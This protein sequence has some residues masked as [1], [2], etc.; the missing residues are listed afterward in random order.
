M[1]WEWVYVGDMED[2]EETWFVVTGVKSQ[3]GYNMNS[4]VCGA[5]LESLCGGLL[6]R[7]GATYTIGHFQHDFRVWNLGRGG[8]FP[9]SRHG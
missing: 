2:L 4:A 8:V 3:A 1:R 5:R 6:V 9:R 7:R